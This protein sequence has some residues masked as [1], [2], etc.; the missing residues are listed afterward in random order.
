MAN[1]FA[2]LLAPAQQLSPLA[3]S[4]R[5][6][7]LVTGKSLVTGG[8]ADDR[9]RI[10]SLTAAQ[11]AG[12]APIAV[13]HRRNA[14]LEQ[15]MV[16]PRVGLCRRDYD[17]LRGRQPEE[18]AELLC[19]CADASGFD[20][21]G[22]FLFL[23][24]ILHYILEREKDLSIFHLLK[25]DARSWNQI[26]MAD[27]EHFL[28]GHVTE[29]T[30]NEL[31]R[32]L[33]QLKLAFPLPREGICLEDAHGVCVNIGESTLAW[34]LALLELIRAQQRRDIR[35]IL[36]HPPVDD[37]LVDLA[38]RNWDGGLLMISGPDLPASAAHWSRL[39]GDLGAILA[40]QHESG[41]SCDSLAQYFGQCERTRTDENVN[42]AQAN[43]AF[44]TKT[45]STGAVHRSVREYSILPEQIQTLPPGHAAIRI[46]GV[47]QAVCALRGR[48]GGDP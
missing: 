10:L 32:F 16:S 40:F 1:P 18:A 27:D 13:L 5:E 4:L 12:A 31:A 26:L 37:V 6:G 43:T 34:H 9:K 24:D 22:M 45:Y 47:G 15:A 41:I 23:S 36:E 42:V 19:A 38:Q 44:L 8:T 30:V 17:P 25:R 2:K 21:N 35:V 28:D 33:A 3:L 46:R 14:R 11:V 39:S 48:E 20:G 7:A 29:K